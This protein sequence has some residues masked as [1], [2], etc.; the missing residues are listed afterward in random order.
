MIVDKLT[1]GPYGIGCGHI[2]QVRQ[3]LSAK[4]YFQGHIVVFLNTVIVKKYD[5]GFS[6]SATDVFLCEIYNLGVG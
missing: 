5:E 3:V 6:E 4:I 2:G 1:Q